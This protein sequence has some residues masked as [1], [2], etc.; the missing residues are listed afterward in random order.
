MVSEGK[1]CPANGK[2]VC[3]YRNIYKYK[4]SLWPY[5]LKYGELISQGKTKEAKLKIG[6]CLADSGI[7]KSEAY[8]FVKHYQT[9]AG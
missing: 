8:P 5:C 4:K 9:P 6:K 2:D 3:I 7:E 1:Y